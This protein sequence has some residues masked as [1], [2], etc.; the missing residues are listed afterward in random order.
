MQYFSNRICLNLHL[1]KYFLWFTFFLMV[2]EI[3]QGISS[4]WKETFS[5][6]SASNSDKDIRWETGCF[7]L[8]VWACSWTGWENEVIKLDDFVLFKWQLSASMLTQG[9]F[10]SSKVFIL[11]NAIVSPNKISQAYSSPEENIKRRTAKKFSWMKTWEFNIIRWATQ[12]LCRFS[13]NQEDVTLA[14]FGK[15][16]WQEVGVLVERHWRLIIFEPYLSE[17]LELSDHFHKL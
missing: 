1:C 13:Q 11:G 15:R 7:A 6:N 5:Q 12:S 3:I 14:H 17:L 4:G 2:N 10:I 9:L 16:V 8:S